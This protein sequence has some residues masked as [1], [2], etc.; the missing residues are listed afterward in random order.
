MDARRQ[1]FH[2]TN[3]PLSYLS[4]PFMTITILGN[5]SALPAYSRHPTAQV[6]SLPGDGDILLDCG[7]GTQTQMQQYSIRWG[8]INHIFI[9]H[10]HG[11]HYFG[12]F[13]LLTTMS[14]L[15]R[16]SP[17]HLY[18]PAPLEELLNAMLSVASSELCY[19]LKF[20]ALP[21]GAAVLVDEK[22][23]SVSCFPVEHRIQCHGFHVTQKTR[24]RRLL[25]DKA[26]SYHIPTYFYDRLKRGEDYEMKHG[27]IIKN[28]WVT[29][30][31][32]APKRYAYCADTIYTESFLEHITGADTIYH[33][34]TYLNDNVQKATERYHSTAAQAAQLAVKAGV[35]QLLL[36]H[37]SSRYKEL[38]G[39]KK[40]AAEIFP[41]VEVT[42]EGDVFEI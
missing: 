8:R 3:L 28:E 31:G 26:A 36:G 10:L 17:L 9:S 38:D 37:Y 16:T 4:L 41:N 18:A 33:E 25:P 11:D 6:I 12:I 39:F 24:G 32:P 23:F 7:E 30:E 19:P 40:E 20:H 27:E 22:V 1:L 42:R 29:A 21:E 2:K 35:K 34:S 15:G 5:N 14:L 13:G